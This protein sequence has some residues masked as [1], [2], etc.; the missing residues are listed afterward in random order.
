VQNSRKVWYNHD[1]KAAI[2]AGTLVRL[3]GIWDVAHLAYRGRRWRPPPPPQLGMILPDD[4][5]PDG[6]PSDYCSWYYILFPDGAK[7]WLVQ[8]SVH[9]I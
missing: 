4:D 7:R 1:M 9:L 8:E 3:D 6:S 5:D 2:K